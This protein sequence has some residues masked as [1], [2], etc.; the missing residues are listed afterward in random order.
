[1]LKVIL[2]VMG[3][4]PALTF[5]SQV[6]TN[7]LEHLLTMTLKLTLNNRILLRKTMCLSDKHWPVT[8]KIKQFRQAFEISD[9]F[10]MTGSHPELADAEDETP[11]LILCWDLPYEWEHR[12]V[13]RNHYTLSG[14]LESW[15]VS[16]RDKSGETPL[17][18]FHNIIDRLRFGI[19]HTSLHLDHHLCYCLLLQLLLLCAL[20][21]SLGIF[22]LQGYVQTVCSFHL[23]LLVQFLHDFQDFLMLLIHFPDAS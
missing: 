3:I 2:P 21:S 6:C 23:N 8:C 7:T 1:M 16:V 18:T 12:T 9:C 22:H 14:T 17:G 10:L 13:L 5:L 15:G 4:F 20:N 19:Q 11:V